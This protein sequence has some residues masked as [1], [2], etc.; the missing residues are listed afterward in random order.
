MMYSADNKNKVRVGDDP[1]AV[2]RHITIN[3]LFPLNDLPVYT[4][5]D[6]PL[7]GYLL[8]PAGYLELEP[9]SVPVNTTDDL[10]RKN[11]SK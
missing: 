6:F 3:R 7:P 10:G 2:D 9:H 11:F 1:L 4:D 8:T 5:H